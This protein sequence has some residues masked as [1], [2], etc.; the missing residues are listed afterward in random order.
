MLEKYEKFLLDIPLTLAFV[1]WASRRKHSSIYLISFMAL[2]MEWSRQFYVSIS[3]R[4]TKI[5]FPWVHLPLFLA[6]AL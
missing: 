1:F 2:S 4:L 3:F 5:F 6:K